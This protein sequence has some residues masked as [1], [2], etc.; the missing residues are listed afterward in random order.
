[1]TASILTHILGNNYWTFRRRQ[2]AAPVHARG[3]RFNVVALLALA[4][5]YTT[6]VALSRALPGVTTQ[7]HQLVA[8]IP[9]TLF[10]YLFNSYRT[11]RDTARP[12]KR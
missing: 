6:F 4:V 10:N 11:F 2:L 12:V 9:A 1:M 3:L 5:S 7:V 8:D